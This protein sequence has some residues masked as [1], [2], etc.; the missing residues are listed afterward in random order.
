ML[1]KKNFFSFKI[2]LF[3]I[4]IKLIT[5]SHIFSLSSETLQSKLN[6][7]NESEINVIFFYKENDED[8]NHYLKIFE[9]ASEIS[10]ND[11]LNYNF[12]KFD[13]AQNFDSNLIKIEKIPTIILIYKKN[14][15]Y[16]NELFEISRLYIKFIINNTKPKKIFEFSE[17]DEIKKNV[18]NSNKKFALINTFNKESETFKD[19][20]KISEIFDMFIFVSCLSKECVKK[21]FR[22]FILLKYENNHFEEILYSEIYRINNNIKKVPGSFVNKFNK[23][24]EFN[25][26][27]NFIKENSINFGEELNNNNNNTNDLINF[28]KYFKQNFIVFFGFDNSFFEVAKDLNKNYFYLRINSKNNNKRNINIFEFNNK[29][30]NI[31]VY[32][33]KEKDF[34][35]ENIKNFINK[36]TNK[37]LEYNNVINDINYNNIFK[38]S[39]NFDEDELLNDL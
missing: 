27:L 14:I 5:N 34:S 7:K 30:N 12:Y 33:F 8:S 19:F 15:I 20:V 21:Y 36:F 29:K 2:F 17:I 3:S 24:P 6:P 35:I 26:I 37:E 18:S 28:I 22:D 16:F 1:N 9:E 31:I 4:T 11:D 10:F 38:I 23:N 39:S 25:E 13:L 32:K